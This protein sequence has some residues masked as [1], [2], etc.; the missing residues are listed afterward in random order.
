MGEHILT[1]FN[2]I[3]K[4]QTTEVS[5][6][7]IMRYTWGFKV[8]MGEFLTKGRGAVVSML[9]KLNKR[10]SIDTDLVGVHDEM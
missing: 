6:G 10:S 7:D 8:H 1:Y 4:P 2:M 5:C 9:Q 3:G